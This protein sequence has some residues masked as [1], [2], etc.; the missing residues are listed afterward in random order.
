[1]KQQTLC[2]LSSQASEELIRAREA[3]AISAA[4]LVAALH[5]AGLPKGSAAVER[6]LARERALALAKVKPED[7]GR[8]AGGDRPAINPAAAR[9]ALLRSESPALAAAFS[10]EAD[11]ML[12]P[13]HVRLE[14][15][16]DDVP[17]KD[18]VS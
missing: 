15:F 9:A 17:H 10:D 16:R 14:V 5:A 1:M 7:G 13:D 8:G 2:H 4:A 11:A 6:R 18:L 3:D 12:G